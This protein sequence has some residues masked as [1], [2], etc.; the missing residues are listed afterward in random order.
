M[1]M[2]IHS[3]VYEN[4]NFYQVMA[5]GRG[6]MQMVAATLEPNEVIA[7]ERH[8]DAD[9][10]VYVMDG[11]AVVTLSL[12][13]FTASTILE[14][15]NPM[16]ASDASTFQTVV[17]GRGEGILIPAGTWHQIANPGKFGNVGQ[18]SGP[19]RMMMVYTSPQHTMSHMKT[20]A[21]ANTTLTPEVA[22]ALRPLPS[23]PSLPSSS[24]S[25]EKVKHPAAIPT[26]V[27]EVVEIE[28][29][30]WDE[31][32]REEDYPEE[33]TRDRRPSLKPSSKKH[34][35]SDGDDDENDDE[36]DDD[37]DDDGNS[38]D[39]S[40]SSSSSGSDEND[41]VTVPKHVPFGMMHKRRP[42]SSHMKPRHP[43]VGRPSHKGGSL[44]L[45]NQRPAKRRPSADSSSSHRIVD[46]L[47][48]D[49]AREV[50]KQVSRT[51]QHLGTNNTTH[52]HHSSSSKKQRHKRREYSDESVP[53]DGNDDRSVSYRKVY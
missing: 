13:E 31:D 22:A 9:Q 23:L 32:D 40:S 49:I 30:E 29:E 21:R 24:S 2:R 26:P 52:S 53:S 37:D 8:A 1:R 42:E 15:A 45:K 4:T 41:D 36:D 14:Q 10:L 20:R 17:I 47:S 7:P 51:M 43:E 18:D 50:A 11:V 6:G 38:S 39:S 33:E 12:T 16:F 48:V 25:R 35:R 28:K 46:D 27:P 34:R 19:V 44:G 3:M 5:T